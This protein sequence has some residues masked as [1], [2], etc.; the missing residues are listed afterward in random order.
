MFFFFYIDIGTTFLY[1]PT[2][3]HGKLGSTVYLK[4]ISPGSL[5]LAI[6]F[7]LKDDKELHNYTNGSQIFNS[8]RISST[9]QLSNLSF[10]DAGHYRCA[11]YNPMIAER[12]IKS[13][14]FAV[15]IKGMLF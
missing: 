7:W 9:I 6:V 5:P 11:A 12:V 3:Y 13:E 4:C 8:T 10:E 14:L 1:V 15:S 2:Q